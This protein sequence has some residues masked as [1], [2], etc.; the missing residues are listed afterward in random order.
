[1]K[2]KHFEGIY[3]KYLAF[4]V[5]KDG[6]FCLIH[7][8]SANA[9]TINVN[10]L[11]KS[12]CTKEQGRIFHLQE[13][14]CLVKFMTMTPHP[15][16]RFEHHHGEEAEW[17]YWKGSYPYFGVASLTDFSGLRV[18]KEEFILRRCPKYVHVIV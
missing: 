12:L 2:R 16:H 10:T 18:L 4:E 1:M 17:F 5:Y 8:L 3:S 13:L 14:I 9:Q 6:R 7:Q 15:H 11:L